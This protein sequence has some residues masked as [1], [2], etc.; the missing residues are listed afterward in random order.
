[1]TFR[2]NYLLRRTRD[3]SKRFIEALKDEHEKFLTQAEY[4][5]GPTQ[6]SRELNKT[7]NTGKFVTQASL[8]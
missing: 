1:M 4:R 3:Y 8:A 5:A 6:L 7:I 2:A